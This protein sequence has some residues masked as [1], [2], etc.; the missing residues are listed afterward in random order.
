MLSKLN[1]NKTEMTPKLKYHQNLCVTNSEMSPKVD[2]TT[3]LANSTP[4]VWHRFSCPCLYRS[5]MGDNNQQDK[6]Y[7]YKNK[8]KNKRCILSQTMSTLYQPSTLFYFK[9][10]N[11]CL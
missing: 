5:P 11:Y 4:G 8:T 1:I 3:R 6:V 7:K 2:C 9:L 10:F